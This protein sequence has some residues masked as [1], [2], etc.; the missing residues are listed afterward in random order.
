[1]TRRAK[2]INAP[3]RCPV[4][5][6]IRPIVGSVPAENVRRWSPPFNDVAV[7]EQEHLDGT[8]LLRRVG[9]LL[10]PGSQRGVIRALAAQSLLRERPAAHR[11]NGA[12]M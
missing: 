4:T 11:L 8:P 2:A 12:A 3:W 7:F 5:E 10:S 1:M 6:P 9:G